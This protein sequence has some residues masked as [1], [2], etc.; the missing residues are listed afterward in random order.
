MP[1]LDDF[2]FQPSQAS[3]SLFEPRHTNTFEGGV[4]YSGP[5][6]G[7]TGTLYYTKLYNITSQGVE[8]V[9]GHPT[10]VT[11]KLDGT[12]G[13]GMEFEVVTR[14]AHDLELRSALTFTNT[15]ATLGPA[16]TGSRYRGLI[17][18]IIDFEAGY[19]VARNT[20]LSFDT[21][22]VG[23][24][25]TTPIGVTPEQKLPSYT[26]ANL[27]G[28]YKFE[29]SGFQI[30]VGLLNVTNSEGLEEG[31]PRNISPANIFN[32]RPI[33]PRRVQAEARY[34]W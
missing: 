6:I 26:Y 3:A 22:Y 27:G 28:T 5:V 34:D 8:N 23:E 17:P 19:T 18:A 1:S 14:P 32:I 4:K 9:N 24:R 11:R 21:H 30:G 12:N 29:G 31:D 10:F 13:W 7:F 25:I 20:R 33:L 15:Q 16:Q 2:L